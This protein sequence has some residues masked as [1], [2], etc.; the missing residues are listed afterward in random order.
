MTKA[1]R[2]FQILITAAALLAAGVTVTH[3]A[4][5]VTAV[6]G[7]PGDSLGFERPLPVDVQVQGDAVD[8][9]IPGFEFGDRT[10]PIDLPEGTY[11]I[12]IRLAAEPNCSGD[13]VLA[14]EGV[15]LSDGINITLIAHRTADGMPGPGDVLGLGITATPFGNDTAAVAPGRAR[16]IAHHTA[17][18]PSVDVVVARNYANPNT[19]AGRIEGFS[20]PTADTDMTMSQI[21]ADFQP[22]GWQIALE[23]DGAAVFGPDTLNLRPFTKTYVYAVGDFPDTFQYLVFTE[24]A[25][26]VRG[27][28]GAAGEGDRADVKRRSRPLR[29]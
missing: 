4:A 3:A 19:E 21:N 25:D 29:K 2:T 8:A 15:A 1:P 22:G 16:L 14:L 6:H 18:A 27:R 13:T 5:T 7:I 26:R 12:A 23:L 10:P 28:S 20:N 24:A 9:C 17:K 11:D